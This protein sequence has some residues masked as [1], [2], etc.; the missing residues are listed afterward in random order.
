MALEF[1]TYRKDVDFPEVLVPIMPGLVRVYMKFGDWVEAGGEEDNIPGECE[2]RL[3]EKAVLVAA[4]ERGRVVGGAAAESW[5]GGIWDLS[6]A[7]VERDKRRRGVW[8]KLAEI[9]IGEAKRAGARVIRFF[10]SDRSK[11]LAKSMKRIGFREGN[12]G[13]EMYLLCGPEGNMKFF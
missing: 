2:E 6:W 13:E 9:R 7:F 3:R 4:L 11:F 10:P 8:T 1:V 5:E 12:D